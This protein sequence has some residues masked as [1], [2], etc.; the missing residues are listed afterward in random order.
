M[1][2]HHLA[3]YAT[4]F[5]TAELNGAFRRTL[6][7][8][9]VRAWRERAPDG[10]IF[11]WKASKFIPHWKRLRDTPRNSLALIEER[12]VTWGQRAGPILF[13]LPP[14]FE[15]DAER[16]ASFLRRLPR[17]RRYAIELRH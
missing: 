2:R 10:F 8:E 17:K 12:P 15:A 14:Q 3:Y 11:A 4:S 7:L 1:L 9:A 5:S 13:Q 6:R 16:L